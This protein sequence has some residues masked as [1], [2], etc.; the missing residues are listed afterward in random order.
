MRL[1]IFNKEK[2]VYLGKGHN[3]CIVWQRLTTKQLGTYNQHLEML[4]LLLWGFNDFLTPPQNTFFY[5]RVC[6]IVHVCNMWLLECLYKNK[7]K[8]TK[9]YFKIYQSYQIICSFL[10]TP[11]EVQCLMPNADEFYLPCLMQSQHKLLAINLLILL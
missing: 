9:L 5:W 2:N 11:D 1:I 4:I 10:H 3:F 8:I 6:I 7:Y